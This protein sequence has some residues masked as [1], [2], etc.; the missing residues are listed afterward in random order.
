MPFTALAMSPT[1]VLSVLEQRADL[2][3]TALAKTLIPSTIRWETRVETAVAWQA[4]CHAAQ[5]VEADLIVIGAHGYGGLD[6]ILGTTAARVVNHADRSVLV[7]RPE[8]ATTG[9][10]AHAPSP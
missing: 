3:L 2:E 7:V 8:T 4:I 5:T 6:R 9:S 10:G 1:D